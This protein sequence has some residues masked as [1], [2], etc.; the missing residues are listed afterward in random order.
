MLRRYI[1]TGAPGSGKTAVLTEL[2]KRGWA[3]VDESATDVIS[4][5]QVRGVPEPWTRD[6]FVS[7]IASLQRQRQERATASDVGV[8]FYDRSPLCTLALARYM[9]L[10]VTR[11]L[12]DEIDHAIAERIYDRAV[13]FV[14]PLGF[15]EPSHARQ[16]SYAESLA[17]QAIHEEVYREYGFEFVDVPAA[18]IAERAA[19]IEASLD[20]HAGRG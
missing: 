20:T 8:Q 7:K 17:F 14:R 9:N 3:I 5:E 4:R 1:V 19:F 11:T 13:F 6:D 15:L 10:P 2:R 18:E 12:T 16:I